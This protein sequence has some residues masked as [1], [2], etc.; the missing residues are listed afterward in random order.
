MVTNASSTSLGERQAFITDHLPR[1]RT[2]LQEMIRVPSLFE[3]EASI[4]DLVRQHIVGLGV[5]VLAVEH[6]SNLLSQLSAA[7]S[8]ISVSAGRSSLVARIPGTGRGRSLIINT[9]L[10]IVPAGNEAD[11]QYPPFAGHIDEERNIIYGR[12]AMDDKAG[13]TISLAVMETIRKLPMQLAGDVIF[14]FVLEDEITGN[15]SLLCLEAG[16]RAD[17]ALIMDGTRPDKAINEHAGQLQFEIRL[18]GKPTSV[19]V[20]HLGVNAAEM[21]SRLLIELREAVFELNARRVDPWTCFPSPY[22]LVIQQI[23][24]E[25]AQLTVPELAT[26][27]CYVTFPPQYSLDEMRSFLQERTVEFA[28][29][30]SLPFLPEM[31]SE[32]LFTA[33]PVKSDTS[34]LERVLQ[35]SASRVGLAPISVGPSTGTSDMRHFS[36]ADIPCMLYGPGNGFNPHRP[37]EHFFLDDVP[38]MTLMYLDIV[39]AWCGSERKR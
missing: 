14:H 25:G 35:E 30:H 20:S 17:A 27:K 11:W 15:G 26:A 39:Q 23:Q 21:I 34:E 8:P 22:Q 31:K 33:E 18:K 32:G 19:S 10:D 9:H 7:Q 2:L 4:V 1:W 5:E 37:D 24:S 6:S 16:H 28:R 13:V 29:R 12:G 3:D 38:R 36:A